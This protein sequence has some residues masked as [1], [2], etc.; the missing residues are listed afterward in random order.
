MYGE[1]IQDPKK[2]VLSTKEQIEAEFNNLYLFLNKGGVVQTGS[3]EGGR[4]AEDCVRRGQADSGGEVVCVSQ[5]WNHQRGDA[6]GHCG[7][8][9]QLQ[10]QSSKS[11]RPVHPAR[12]TGDPIRALIDV[13]KHLGNLSFKV[14]MKMKEQFHLNAT[15]QV[16]D[17]NTALSWLE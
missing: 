16:L 9:Q 12:S 1:V 14:W 3:S 5:H 17:P 13:A 7:F 4:G 2:H 15:V 8:P 6:D 10:R 11:Q